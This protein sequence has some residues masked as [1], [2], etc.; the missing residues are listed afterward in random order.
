[1]RKMSFSIKLTNCLNQKIMKKLILFILIFSPFTLL[2]AQHGVL[3]AIN[4][5]KTSGARSL[6]YA[7]LKFLSEDVHSRDYNLEGLKK[8]TILDLDE[9]MVQSLFTSRNDFIRIMIP[10]SERSE[11][12]LILKRYEIFTPDFTLYTSS[13]PS[14][15]LD[16]VPGLHYR[17]IVES[18]PSSIVALSVFK[19]EVMGLIATAEG[20]FVVGP[21]EGNNENEHIFYNDRDL[22]KAFDFECG[23]EDDDSNSPADQHKLT[24]QRDVNDC[25]RLHVEIDYNV[26]T[27]KGGATNA[28]NYITAM[29]N[30]SFL[31]YTQESINMVI[32]EIFAWTTPSPYVGATQSEMLASYKLNTEYF[33]G[34]VSQLVTYSAVGGSAAGTDGLCNSNPDLSKCYSHIDTSFENVPVYSW[35]VFVITHE[36]GHLLGSAH[37]HACAWNGN[38]TAIDGCYAPSGSCPMPP[39]P[40][41][42]GTIM[43]YC[44]LASSG[45]YINYA[46]GFGPQPGDRI[47]NNVNASSNC[48]SPCGQPV[49]YCASNGATGTNEYIKKVVLGNINNTSE[50]NNGYA[51]FTS[52]SANINAGNTYTITLTPNFTGGNK[53]KFWRVWIDYNHDFDWYDT[54]EI[55]AQG[56]GNNTIS[57][58]FTVPPGITSISTRMRV[59]MKLAGFAVFCGSFPSGEVEDYTVNITGP[60]AT[61]SDGIQNQGEAGID[62]G[63]PCPACATCNDG[64]QNQGETG[65]DCGGPCSACPLGGDVILLAAYFETGWDSWIDGG[66]D[67]NRVSSAN[68]YE[69]QYSIRLNDNSGAASSMTSPTFNLS[70]ATGLSISFH[71]YPTSMETDEDFLVQYKSGSTWTTIASY[72]SG[73]QF[74]NNSFYTA[75]VDVPN[76]VPTSTG[77][78][79]IQCDANDNNDQVYFDQ[80][81]I[82]KHTGG[83]MAALPQMITEY[84][85]PSLRYRSG[86]PETGEYKIYPNPNHGDFTI[87]LPMPAPE[88]LVLRVL[89]YTGQV[90][91]E[92]KAERGSASQKLQLSNLANGM[93]F[94]QI[95]SS[96]QI[97]H[98]EKIIKQ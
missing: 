27:D 67:A 89:S 82:I 92:H 66:A 63:G 1:M 76:F 78:L 51:N 38:N 7:P 68:S 12:V 84:N 59:S 88:N 85:D 5:L 33:N 18:D 81:V 14:A 53:T 43:S 46:N 21:I 60:A 37:T 65:I 48:L 77:T 83:A 16:Y 55:V 34:D 58:T 56:T 17:G 10:Y 44:Y 8:G 50:N 96:G 26:V 31:I 98:F 61:C 70:N 22:E 94:L 69:G 19:N 25:V 87:E 79:R 93:Y 49:E 72:A 13:Q 41:N 35:T 20:N 75:T 45:S 71:Y 29:F 2:L 74:N 80:V 52:Q 62:C 42:G 39:I 15:S 24:S 3:D 86:S 95:I 4:E 90:I 11:M 9:K 47:R 32:S 36:V 73:T 40:L 57:L 64:I 23:T 6:P 30:Q 54:G 91:S 28:I 97:V